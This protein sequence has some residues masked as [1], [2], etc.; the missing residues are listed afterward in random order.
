MLQSWN[1]WFPCLSV[2]GV[3]GT[4]GFAILR[5]LL[6]LSVHRLALKIGEKHQK[7]VRKCNQEIRG[8]SSGNP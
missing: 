6:Q 2:G 4:M 5:L 8:N 3:L 7:S 1:A